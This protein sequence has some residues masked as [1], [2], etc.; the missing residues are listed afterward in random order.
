MEQGGGN[1]GG[2][3]NNKDDLLSPKSYL[4]EASNTL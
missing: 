4:R 2:N 1:G 3:G